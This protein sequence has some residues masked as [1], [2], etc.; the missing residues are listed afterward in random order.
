MIPCLVRH[1][2]LLSVPSNSPPENIVTGPS[3]VTAPFDLIIPPPSSA[4]MRSRFF[5]DVKVDSFVPFPSSTTVQTQEH[6]SPVVE[7]CLA[8]S[9]ADALPSSYARGLPCFPNQS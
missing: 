1:R 7:G 2:Y 9:R 8:F 3:I 4:A 5:D 6:I